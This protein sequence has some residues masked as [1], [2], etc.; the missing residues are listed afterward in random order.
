MAN[1]SETLQTI[2]SPAKH[3]QTIMAEMLP[4]LQSIMRDA[5]RA[6]PGQPTK[7]TP[8][9]IQEICLDMACG[10]SLL[11]VCQRPDMPGY[12]TVMRWCQNDDTLLETFDRARE[13][14]AYTIDEVNELIARKIAPFS[15]GDFRRDELL[16]SINN[17]RKR[18]LNKKR[19][20]EK[21]Q[22][23]H[24]VQ[25]VFVMPRDAIEGDGY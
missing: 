3:T 16:V 9:L 11:V 15:T 22:V 7:R 24:S 17:Q 10:D 18:H 13:M 5:T 6:R 14:T 25:P 8:E 23:E 21:V 12:S 4:E 20:T 2:P 1:K 19:F